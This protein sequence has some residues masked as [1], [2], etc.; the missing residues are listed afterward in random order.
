VTRRLLCLWVPI[1]AVAAAAFAAVSAPEMV[2]R[3]KHNRGAIDIVILTFRQFLY[4][5][6]GG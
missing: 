3:G 6:Y 5:S 1:W 4:R 2:T